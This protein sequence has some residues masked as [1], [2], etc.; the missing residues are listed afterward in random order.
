MAL[1]PTQKQ[2]A[3]GGGIGAIALAIGYALFHTRPAFGAPL[4]HQ[5]RA[6]EHRKRKKHPHERRDHGDKR[7]DH[8]DEHGGN[9]R[10][11]YGRKKKRHHKGRKHD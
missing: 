10:G 7:H 6:P 8:G 9:D 11:E 5:L 1:T 2:W 3:I 4:P